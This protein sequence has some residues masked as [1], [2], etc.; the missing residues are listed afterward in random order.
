MQKIGT[1][2]QINLYPVKSMRGVSVEKA[3]CYWYGLN[4]DRKLAFVHQDDTSGFPWVTAREIPQLLQYQPEFVSPDDPMKSVVIVRTPSGKRLSV[5]SQELAEELMSTYEKPVTLVKLSRGTFDCMPASLLT[6]TSLDTLQSKLA[7]AL[8]A[9]RFRA[10]V[11][12]DAEV[13]NGYPE[14]DWINGLVSFGDRADSAQVLVNYPDKRC[15]MVNLD[16]E[17]GQS[18]PDLLKKVVKETNS[19]FSVYASVQKLGTIEVGNSVF[20]QHFES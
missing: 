4:G 19:C 12:I 11:I 3:T 8:D 2:Q 13:K 20:L 16:P 6:Q 15:M 7:Y 14:N 17:T 9:R 18:N 10:N 1:V 5:D